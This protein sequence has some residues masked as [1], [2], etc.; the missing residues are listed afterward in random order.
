[1]SSKRMTT[2]S[3]LISQIRMGKKPGQQEVSRAKKLVA[4]VYDPSTK[5]YRD[6]GS[7]GEGTTAAGTDAGAVQVSKARIVSRASQYKTEKRERLWQVIHEDG[8]MS[9]Q[10]LHFLNIN[11][12]QNCLLYTSPS[13]R[14]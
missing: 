7:G 1:M 12:Y 4:K 8:P 11:G 3:M 6:K 5:L 2:T 9:S 13:P 10:E 14:D